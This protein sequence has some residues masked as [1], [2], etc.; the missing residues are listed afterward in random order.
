M[1]AHDSSQ[2]AVTAP[3]VHPVDVSPRKPAA[4]TQTEEVQPAPTSEVVTHTPAGPEAD[5]LSRAQAGDHH[6]FAQLYALHKRLK[7]SP[8]RLSSSCIEKSPHSAATPHSPPGCIVSLSM[9]S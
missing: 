3:G 6:A 5:V 9:S 2:R 7:T 4:S 8:R 1:Q